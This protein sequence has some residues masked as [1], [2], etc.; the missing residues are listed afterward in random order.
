M[1]VQMKDL[2]LPI[3]VDAGAP[4]TIPAQIAEQ[5]KL[6]IGL[7]KLRPNQP[8]PPVTNLAKYL[9]VGRCTVV[10]VY[11]QLTESGYLVAH[12]GKGTFIADSLSVRQIIARK[13]FYDLLGQAWSLA[14][15]NG[16]SVSDF[17]AAA[18]AKAI[19]TKCHRLSLVFVNFFPDTIDIIGRLDAEIGIPSVS[20]PW[21]SLEA[22]EPQALQQLLSADLV[23][24]TIKNLWDVSC[25]TDP[26]QE[27]IGIEVQPDVELLNCILALPRNAKLLFVCR[28]QTSSEAMKQ[29][30]EHNIHYLESKAVT[31]E[32]V[33]NNIPG[34]QEFDLAVC[35]RQVESELSKYV[36]RSL[37]LITFS[38]RIDPVNLLI[39]QARMTSVEMEKFV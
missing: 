3:V 9:G 2:V 12:K 35:S 1:L 16:L 5:I 24:T 34:L 8:L 20:I 21:A 28:E 26:N 6:L 7:G 39:L 33:Q 30:V 27:V 4:I 11:N 18:Y 10:S 17:A 14:S 25:V 13:N 19:Q 31:L 37:E 29:I 23:I 36:P 38:I 32:C 22:K 15:Q